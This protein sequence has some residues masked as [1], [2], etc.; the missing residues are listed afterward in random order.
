M[1]KKYNF[2]PKS[3]SPNGN[4]KFSNLAEKIA[5]LL[6]IAASFIWLWK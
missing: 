4:F 6:L 1:Y 2:K 3:L 5:P